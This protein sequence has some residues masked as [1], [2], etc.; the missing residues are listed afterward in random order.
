MARPLRIE[1]PGAV[2]HLTARGNRQESIFL[3]D[4]DRFGF[5]EILGKTIV[6]YNWLCHAYC[7]M[8]NHY[9]LL[10]ETIDA[11]LSIGM[12]QLN[13]MYTQLSNRNHKK[14]G[15][16]FQGRFKSILIER[17]SYLLELCRYIVCNP[18][19][20]GI[21]PKP[22][23]WGWSSYNPTAFGRNVPEYL[24]VDW[25]LSQFSEDNKR[26]RKL[27]REFVTAG[28]TKQS[29]P[30]EQVVGQVMLG[31]EEFIEKVQGHLAGAEGNSEIPRSQRVAGR[32]TLAEMFVD[33][34]MINKAE[35]NEKIRRAHL[36]FGY[37][38]KEIAD[39]IGIHY[40]TVSRVVSR[41]PKK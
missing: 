17:D 32:P 16:V 1:F 7:L 38:L 15:H 25:I 10:V 18:V 14:V 30:W 39:Y 2:Y 34:H 24:S 36:A 37:S 3:S 31:G 28:L 13:G 26:A 40:T 19:K 33:K 9:H 4:E 35:R 8:D 22:G 27:Y 11:N 5:L 29:S 21:C 20:A 6:R 41:E 23:D 12:R